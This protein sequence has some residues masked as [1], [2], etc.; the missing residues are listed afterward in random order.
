MILADVNV[1]LAT[2]VEQHPHHRAAANWWRK[3]VLPAGNQVA[4]CR[5]TQLG[6]LRLLTNDRVMGDQ[7]RT[8]QQ[9]FGDYS[10][11]LAQN[12]VVY[13]GEPSGIDRFVKAHCRIGGSSRNFWTESYLAAFARAGRLE[14]ATFDR[15]F[16]KFPGLQLRLLQ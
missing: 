13:S 5:L 1:W 15:G 14:L 9:A 10:L 7:K 8:L 2:V 16:H 6:L 3:E 4:F 12:P 11:L